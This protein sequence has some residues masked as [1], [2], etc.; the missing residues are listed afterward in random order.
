MF[1]FPFQEYLN[2]YGY[3]STTRMGT[4]NL[5][6]E[7]GKSVKR[8]QRFA[9]LKETGDLSDPQTLALLEKSRCGL[10]DIGN[11]RQLAARYAVHGANWKKRVN[12][13]LDAFTWVTNQTVLNN[14]C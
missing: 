11:S 12:L 13:D 7:L 10:P 14:N 6:G 9:G 2:K 1:P 3:L 4:L 8:L 5:D